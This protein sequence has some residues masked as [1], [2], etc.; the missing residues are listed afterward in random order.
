MHK[1]GAVKGNHNRRDEYK[2]KYDSGNAPAIKALKVKALP[3][4]PSKI[5]CTQPQTS[6]PAS[7]AI[8]SER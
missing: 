2:L 3:E 4:R 7:M 6:L 1:P 5:A 8:I